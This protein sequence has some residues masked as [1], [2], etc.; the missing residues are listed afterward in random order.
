MKFLEFLKLIPEGMH[1]PS[2]VIEGAVN[3]VKA[4]Y[5]LLPED[6]QEE[7]VRRRLI[8]ASCPFSSRNKEGARQKGFDYCTLCSCPI[9]QKSSALGASCGAKTWN[10]RHPDKESIEVKWGPYGKH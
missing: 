6:E 9:E 3:A 2:L 1:N 4:K 8:C 10:E 5:S 7:I